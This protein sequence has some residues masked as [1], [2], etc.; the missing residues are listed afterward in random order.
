MDVKRELIARTAQLSDLEEILNLF[1][2]TIL[3]TCR[4]DYNLESRMR[5]ASDAE[6]VGRWHTSILKDVFI[7][8]IYKDRI[9]GFSTLK[10]GNFIGFMYVHKS[11]IRKGIASILYAEL[12]Q[13][14]RRLGHSALVVDAS[15]TAKPF[16][17]SK[18]FTVL[19][20]NEVVLDKEVLVNYRMI[21]IQE[22]VNGV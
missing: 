13:K 16:F 22:N 3:E 2:Q 8:A 7:V 20:K 1:Q 9:V 21:R 18:G 11:Y 10:D 4:K 12:A 15:I 19:K 17:K 14:S 6:Q 5:W